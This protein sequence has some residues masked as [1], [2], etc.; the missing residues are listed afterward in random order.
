MDIDKLMLSL[1]S[2]EGAVFVDQVAGLDEDFRLGEFEFS[3]FPEVLSYLCLQ[4][5]EFSPSFHGLA[6]EAERGDARAD[7][8]LVAVFRHQCELTCNDRHRGFLRNGI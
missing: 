6:V 3:G 4:L 2:D 7:V 5:R 8:V 1:R